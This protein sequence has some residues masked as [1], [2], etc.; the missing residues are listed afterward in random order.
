MSSDSEIDVVSVRE[1]E[2][3]KI[4]RKRKSYSL[5]KKLEV[6]EY[7]KKN[8]KMA[9]AKRYGIDRRCIIDW[10]KQEEKLKSEAGLS[11]RLRGGGRHMK[12]SQ[13]D[14]ELAIW[15]REKR[16]EKHR[17]SRRLIQQQALKFFVPT[18]EEPDFKASIGWLQKF[19][20]RHNFRV[21]VP[22]TVCQKEPEQYVNVL[23]NFVMFIS[24]LREKKKF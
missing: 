15:V 4:Y 3:K 18:E 16:S 1:E 13:L 14:E 5:N 21:R 10:F 2:P 8:S 17:V 6:I 12:Y 9:A 7:A 24:Q 11:K 19:M 23:V 22:T 20:K